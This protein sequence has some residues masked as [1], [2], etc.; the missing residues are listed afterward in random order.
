M[1]LEL[2]KITCIWERHTNMW[3]SCW[4]SSC[5][6]Q[7]L[8]KSK[9]AQCAMRDVQRR[10]NN[11]GPFLKEQLRWAIEKVTKGTG[12]NIPK[13]FTLSCFSFYESLWDGH[14]GTQQWIQQ[15]QQSS[16]FS[17]CS[18]QFLSFSSLFFL[19]L[20]SGLAITFAY[21]YIQLFASASSLTNQ[22]H[23]W[24]KAT[25]LLFHPVHGS[26]IIF[27]WSILKCICIRDLPGIW[28]TLLTREEVQISDTDRWEVNRGP[29]ADSCGCPKKVQQCYPR[30][31]C[32]STKFP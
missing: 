24:F 1:W 30:C 28:A 23:P 13:L 32:H 3:E 12:I 11:E 15:N 5:F 2:L 16:V 20:N 21:V 17:S 26:L 25:D 8:P 31:D 18:V 7:D 6:R 4:D 22:C 19:H 14:V 9:F 10:T 29:H 27:D